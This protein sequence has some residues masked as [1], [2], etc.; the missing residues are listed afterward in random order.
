MPLAWEF[1]G[2]R[3]SALLAKNLTILD[4]VQKR[5]HMSQGMWIFFGM[6]RK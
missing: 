1:L 3:F 6:I 5:I 2:H 4:I